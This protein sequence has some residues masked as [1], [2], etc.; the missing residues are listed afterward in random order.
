MLCCRLLLIAALVTTQVA[1]PVACSEISVLWTAFILQDCA[2]RCTP[3][4]GSYFC[5]CI[6]EMSVPGSTNPSGFA[7]CCTVEFKEILCKQHSFSP[8]PLG[9]RRRMSTLAPGV[10]MSKHG[11][12]AGI[13]FYPIFFS[14]LVVV[15]RSWY[16]AVP[17]SSMV[18]KQPNKGVATIFRVLGFR[19]LS[20]GLTI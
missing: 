4:R 10:Q 14:F 5:E 6:Y 12:W 11:W 20:S 13:F 1:V 19:L 3:P 2:E 15:S 18:G 7:G 17:G 8:P 16:V 9:R